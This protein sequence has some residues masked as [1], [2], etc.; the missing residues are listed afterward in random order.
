MTVADMSTTLRPAGP[1]VSATSKPVL[2]RPNLVRK[3][4]DDEDTIPSSPG[5]RAKV[6]FDSDVEVRVVDDW[7]Q[8]P[9]VIYEEVRRAFSKRLSGDSSG[10]EKVKSIYAANKDDSD[11]ISSTTLR[12]YTLALL[13]NV[14]AL[15]KSNSDLVHTVL[16]SEW[17]RRPEDYVTLYVRLLANLASVQGIF[18]GEIMRMLVNNI[19]ATAPSNG[20]LRNLP[21]VPRSMVYARVH[22]AIR[23]L[24]QVMPSASRILASSLINAFPHETES[25]RNHIIYVQNLLQLIAY[26]PQLREEVLRLITERLVKID[27]RIQVDLEELAEEVGEGLVN[28]VRPDLMEDMQDSDSSEEESDSEEYEEDADARRTKDITK[29]VEKMDAILDIL[30]SHYDQVFTKASPEDQL[31]SFN[32]LLSQFTTVILPTHR[33][34]HTQ[35]LIFHFSQKSTAHIDTFVGACAQITF[36]RNQPAIIRQASTA[37]LASFVA[38]GIHVPSSIVREVF[39]YLARELEHY[40][41]QNEPNCRGPDMRRYSSFYVLV[42]AMLYIFCFRWR[43][44]ESSPDDDLEDDDLEAY[45]QQ[46]QWRSGVKEALSRNIFSKLN[47]LKVC[48][49]TIVTEFSCLANHLGIVYVYHLLE[50]NKRVRVQQYAGNTYSQINRETALSARKDEDHQYLDEY[51]PFDPYHLPKSKRWIDGDYREWAAIG[52]LEDREATDS[53]SDEE[54]TMDSEAEEDTET[55]G[56]G[57]SF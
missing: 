41:R 43:D 16:K 49:P 57:I 17:V 13:G 11:E 44:L 52:G 53:G 12:S 10:Y 9:E 40:R 5:K 7:D 20:R 1:V 46:Y 14:S 27:V 56:T 31:G 54:E 45:G 37:Y 38:R 36:D 23:F 42:Q 6:T 8:A 2:R 26:A 25:R 15:T 35:F 32:V 4:D 55:D 24:L 28:K 48:S 33:S 3:R 47:P 22:K 39:D 21:V 51:F 19:T 29:N 50:T 34:R 18:L 30:F